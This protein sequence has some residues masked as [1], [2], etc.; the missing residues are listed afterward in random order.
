VDPAQFIPSMIAV[1]V[2]YF[3]TAPIAN[4][5][6]GADPFSAELLARRRKA[7]VDFVSHA[8][9]V[10]HAKPRAAAEHSAHHAK[11]GERR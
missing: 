8:L 10:P 7:T 9:F 2:F 5:M 11:R 4:V 6:T 3:I 1:V